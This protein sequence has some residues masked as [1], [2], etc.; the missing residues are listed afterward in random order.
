[1]SKQKEKRSVPPAPQPQTAGGQ[2][3]WQPVFSDESQM[4]AFFDSF[5][6]SVSG[7]IRELAAARRQGEE[8]V[9]RGFSG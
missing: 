8:T 7:D 9:M 6:E 3:G 4:W 1:M 2:P 5:S